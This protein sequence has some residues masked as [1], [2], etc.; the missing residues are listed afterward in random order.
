MALQV[1]LVLLL[2]SI[3][4]AEE[5]PVL[6]SGDTAWMLTATALVLFMTI[7]GLS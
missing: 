4:M 3:A 5:A 2:P 1:A 7:P 6:S